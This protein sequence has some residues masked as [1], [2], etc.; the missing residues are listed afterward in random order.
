MALDDEMMGYYARP[1]WQS[2]VPQ[3]PQAWWQRFFNPP[4]KNNDGKPDKTSSNPFSFMGKMPGGFNPF[5]QPQ[6]PEIPVS[7]PQTPPPQ[8]RPQQNV[9]FMAMPL[10]SQVQQGQQM[11][12]P[13]PPFGYARRG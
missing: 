12:Q 2:G 1:A 7:A 9:Y 4:D 11:A 10:A 5:A 6:G 3:E 13:R 8:Q